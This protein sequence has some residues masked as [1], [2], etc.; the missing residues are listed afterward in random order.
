MK[1]DYAIL[2]MCY[3]S[4][5]LAVF[6]ISLID[7]VVVPSEVSGVSGGQITLTCTF[8]E[9]SSTPPTISWTKSESGGST[10]IVASSVS[11]VSHISN[12]FV[13]R[14]NLDGANL[15][16][17]LLKLSDSGS[18][19]CS[20]IAVSNP[21]ESGT[22]VLRVTATPIVSAFSIKHRVV[23]SNGNYAAAVCTAAGGKPRAVVT[24]TDAN[25][26]VQESR[27]S[28]RESD[29]GSVDVESVLLLTPGLLGRSINST[30][31][32]AAD[33][34]LR[35]FFCDVT[36]EN[37]SLNENQLSPKVVVELLYAPIAHIS[38]L[39]NQLT[40]N[41]EGNPKPTLTWFL[42]D[43]SIA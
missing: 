27:V 1:L 40:C 3:S 35:E 14:A 15:T 11:G 22:T 26:E 39:G 31:P 21:Q 20:V 9:T 13:D 12:S 43:G 8:V 32:V 33:D 38:L 2:K 41:V 17:S 10:R 5:V 36:H 28:A 25:G 42:P 30:S 16:I 23:G 6:S 24:W 7:A 34:K 19:T 29:D 18:Y 37:W 4:V